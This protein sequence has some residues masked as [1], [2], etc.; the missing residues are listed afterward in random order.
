MLVNIIIA[1]PR[2]E[3]A[4]HIKNLLIRYGY[5]V[6]AVCSTGAQAIA[7]A[8]ELNDGILVCG[9]KLSDMMYAELHE[10]LPKHFDMLLVASARVW[11]DCINNDIVC[12]AMPVK[13]HDFI[14][15]VEMMSGAVMQR[16]RRLKA[17]PKTRDSG[18]RKVIDQ[19][20]RLLMERNNMSEEEA[21]RYIQKNSMDSGTNMVETAQMV[22]TLMQM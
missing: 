13:V 18:E 17:K 10:C 20:K 4:K 16:R 1:F 9:Y 3:D 22:L 8:D 2:L 14:N 11:S 12:V 19:A 5:Q 7:C 21:Y 6:S 15:T